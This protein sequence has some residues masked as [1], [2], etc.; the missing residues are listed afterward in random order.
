[1]ARVFQVPAP[2]PETRRGTPLAA[3]IAPLFSPRFPRKN[4]RETRFDVA[5]GRIIE[6]FAPNRSRLQ[7]PNVA[8]SSRYSYACRYKK[9][10]R[11]DEQTNPNHMSALAMP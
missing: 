5:L 10:G 11:A 8:A 6:P 9:H 7:T 4:T 1:M 2:A 3:S